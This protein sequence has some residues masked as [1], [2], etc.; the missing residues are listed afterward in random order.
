MKFNL[1]TLNKIFQWI[2]TFLN[3]INF[4]SIELENIKNIK[5]DKALDERWKE[6]SN[7]EFQFNFKYPKNENNNLFSIENN[8]YETKELINSFQNLNFEFNFSTNFM[9]TSITNSSNI[10]NF[11]ILIKKKRFHLIKDFDEIL[12]LYQQLKLN[13]LIIEEE[14]RNF[15]QKNEEI[16]KKENENLNELIK[17]YLYSPYLKDE[18]YRKLNKFIFKEIPD[19]DSLFLFENNFENIENLKLKFFKKDENLKNFSIL[20]VLSKK[21]LKEREERRKILLDSFID[22]KNEISSSIESDRISSLLNNLF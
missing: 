18:Y 6:D 14:E 20:K 13:S 2:S 3:Q 10:S 21:T 12:K 19:N 7:G 17:N 16:Q 8:F 11:N 4:N 22:S 1:E 5:V 9:E 15:E